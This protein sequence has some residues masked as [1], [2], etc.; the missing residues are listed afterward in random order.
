MRKNGNVALA[1]ALSGIAATL[2]KLGTTFHRRFGVPIPCLSDSSSR[3][4]LNSKQAQLIRD[5]KII[6]IDEVSMMNYKLLDLLDRFLRILMGNDDCMGGKLVVLMHDFRQ[7]LPVV[8]QGRR[9]DIIAAAVTISEIWNQFKPLRLKQNMRVQRFLQTN[10]SPLRAQKLL[11]YSNWL[12]KLGDG[13]LP[14]AVQNVP[15]IIEVPDQ[16]VCK[17]HRELEDKVYNDFLLN[18]Q[19]PEYLKTRAIMSST[20]DIIQQQNFEMVE[21]LP[22]EMVISNSID[23]CVEKTVILQLMMLKYSTRSILQVSHLIGWL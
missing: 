21:R 17:S 19:D 12:L 10:P 20:N 9:A 11:D 15:G 14:S 6:M 16:M 22:G 8:S 3:I 2:L 18:Y 5:A 23:S 13:K 7:I 1:T 4:R